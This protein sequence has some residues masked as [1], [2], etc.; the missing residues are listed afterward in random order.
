MD[1]GQHHHRAPR[2]FEPLE[3]A[4]QG[5]RFRQLRQRKPYKFLDSLEGFDDVE[6]TD[7]PKKEKVNGLE[8]AW[9]EGTIGY[10]PSSVR[11][12]MTY[13]PEFYKWHR[14][15]WE[16]IFQTL[17]KQ[18]LDGVADDWELHGFLSCAK[19]EP[20]QLMRVGHGAAHARFRDRPIEV[21]V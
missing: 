13:H 1:I 17:P 8:Q 18:A 3:A 14:A 20:L 9:Y 16:I 19:G 21:R 10:L 2:R 5:T 4:P 6:V 7:G 12:A 11:F 15:R